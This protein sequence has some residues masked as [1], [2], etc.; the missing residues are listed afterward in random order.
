[1][2]AVQRLHTKTLILGAVLAALLT[3]M[4]VGN[5]GA[6]DA[7]YKQI[8]ASAPQTGANGER[9]VS[10]MVARYGGTTTWFEQSSGSNKARLIAEVDGGQPAALP[11]APFRDVGDVDLGPDGNGGVVAAYSRCQ[12]QETAP[13]G[14]KVL[15]LYPVWALR[16]GCDL[17]R[18]DFSTMKETKIAG[19]STSQASEFL[20][21]IWK[22]QIAFARVYEKRSGERGLL[23]YIYVRNLDGTG[24]SRRQPGGSRGTMGLPGPSRMD[25]YG[26]RLSFVWNHQTNPIG[27]VP[28]SGKT[29]LRLDTVGHS[30]RVVSRS[31]WGTR[32]KQGFASFI[33]PQGDR[34]RIR[35]GFQRTFIREGPDTSKTSLLETYGISNRERT[36]ASAPDFLTDLAADAGTTAIAAGGTDTAPSRILL[37]LN[38]P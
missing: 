34:G 26:K 8:A 7:G 33:G 6:S 22:D 16:R 13:G 10:G 38:R 4:G 15:S 30:H 1:M 27:K 18:F 36:I 20:P 25:L 29:E 31:E 2:P 37:G 19:A 11:V 28:S 5:A 35:F 12:G 3:L 21:T 17:Y 14:R 32:D 9:I 23:P 24:G